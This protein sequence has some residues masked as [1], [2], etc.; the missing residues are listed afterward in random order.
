MD[1]F[2]LNLAGFNV[3]LSLRK[4]ENLFYQRRLAESIRKVWG[5]GGYFGKRTGKI[6]FEI[7][8]APTSGKK[9]LI[10]AK[11][12]GCKHYYLMSERNFEK[13]RIQT[14][15]HISLPIFS[16]MLQDVLAF[17]L[18]KEGF[19]LHA[20]SCIDEKKKM[21][22]FMAES[23]GG[24]S[25]IAD[26]LSTTGKLK[27]VSDDIVVVR[28]LK[29][30]W[31]FFSPP[32]IE[33]DRLPKLVLSKKAKLFFI[34]KSK[35]AFAKRLKNKTKILKFFLSQV[36]LREEKFDKEIFKTVSHFVEENCF[37]KLHTNLKAKEVKKAIYEA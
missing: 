7:V 31:T 29:D 35:K 21:Y 6:D 10:L 28:K 9:M 19:L 12:K 27:K 18:K 4:T 25:T 20:S 26:L 17:L 11:E 14:G 24:K 23:E 8:F 32:F 33:K 30:T 13:R 16:Y 3:K 2:F 22:L 37:Y 15:Y 34:E 1:E 5:K 36:W